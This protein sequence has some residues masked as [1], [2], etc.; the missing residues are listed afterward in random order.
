MR[1]VGKIWT[2]PT[3]VLVHFSSGTGDVDPRVIENIKK[4]I[5]KL[6]GVKSGYYKDSKPIPTI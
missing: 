3:V 4:Y 5:A 1:R 2:A 6:N